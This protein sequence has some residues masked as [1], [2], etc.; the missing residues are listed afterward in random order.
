M[1]SYGIEA[2]HPDVFLEHQMSLYP[3]A[4]LA[5]AKAHRASLKR[6]PK[7]AEEYITTLSAQRLVVTADKL[8]EFIESI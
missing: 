1:N 8:R 4:F 5:V 2:V 6:P 7:S 3:G